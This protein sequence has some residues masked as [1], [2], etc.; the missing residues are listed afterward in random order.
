MAAPLERRHT[1]LADAIVEQWNLYYRQQ[2]KLYKL[3]PTDPTD[4]RVR[5]FTAQGD[6]DHI[7]ATIIESHN[8][9]K[10]AVNS[11][12]ETTALTLWID[13]DTGLTRAELK[14]PTPAQLE[15]YLRC[16]PELRSILCVN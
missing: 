12:R 7:K 3:I 5:R 9:S 1:D 10:T 8:M 4:G 11:R 13:Y 6:N 16:W 15:A 14:R 2:G